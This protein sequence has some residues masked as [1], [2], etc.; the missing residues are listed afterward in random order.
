MKEAAAH[1]R[2]IKKAVQGSFPNLGSLAV[3]LT[4]AQINELLIDVGV[5]TSN[6]GTNTVNIGTNT[7]N[8]SLKKDKTDF[9]RTGSRLDI[10]NVPT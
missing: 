9:L 3:T 5:N 10:N 4:A 8:I 7:S 2:G 6:I 1:L